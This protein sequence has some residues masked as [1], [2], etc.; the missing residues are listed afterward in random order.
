MRVS[1]PR[2]ARTPASAPVSS[3]AS[4]RL[5]APEV[6]GRLS[7]ETIRRLSATAGNRA[8][9]RVLARK[10]ARYNP[11]DKPIDTAKELRDDY[12]LNTAEQSIR[13][14][15]SKTD[16]KLRGTQLQYLRAIEAMQRSTKEKQ[17]PTALLSKDES[18][19]LIERKWIEGNIASAGSVR[20]GFER[21]A[22]SSS[23]HYGQQAALLRQDIKT[24]QEEFV[25][26]LK[27]NAHDMLDDSQRRIE[28][29]LKGY[30]LVTASADDAVRQVF[31]W[32]GDLD[33]EVEEWLERAKVGQKAI[34]ESKAAT[35][36]REGLSKTI[37]QLRKLQGKILDLQAAFLKK[38][39]KVPLDEHDR[40][41]EDKRAKGQSP[42]S[43]WVFGTDIEPDARKAEEE[44]QVA[45]RELKA[46]WI[47]AERTH[48]IL[49]AHR[50]GQQRHLEFIDLGGYSGSYMPGGLLTSW[51]QPGKIQEARQNLKKQPAKNAHE[52]AVIKQALRKL[53]NIHRARLA[54]RQGK[55]S[56]YKLGPVVE[57]TREQ[58]LIHPRSVWGVAVNELINPHKGPLEE[59]L[60]FVQDLF[61]IAMMLLAAIPNPLQPVAVMY[62]VARGT[63]VTMEEYVKYDLQKSFSD[64]DLDKARSISDEEPSLTGFVVSL[65]ATGMGAAQARTVFK[66]AAAARKAMLAGDDAARKTLNE[67][68]ERH[69][70]GKLGD[71]VARE[72]GITTTPARPTNVNVKPTGKDAVSLKDPP[73]PKPPAKPDKP[74]G[75]DPTQGP[76][77]PGGKRANPLPAPVD[78]PPKMPP[79]IPKPKLDDDLLL[80]PK[81]LTPI[82]YSD[83]AKVKQ[84][85]ADEFKQ[86]SHGVRRSPEEKVLLDD[87][88]NSID[89]SAESQWLKSVYN[90]YYQTLR[91]P[92]A[93]AEFTAHVWQHAAAKNMTPRQ[94]L[95]DL[96]LGGGK[97]TAVTDQLTK[98]HMSKEGGIIDLAFNGNEHGTH[99]HLFQEGLLNFKHG[100]G[101]GKRFRR[102]IGNAK[103]R[104]VPARNGRMKEF[105]ETFWDAMFDVG[106]GNHI[107]RPE[108][109]QPVLERHLGLPRRIT[110]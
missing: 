19:K 44:I 67:L 18:D 61:N 13:V 94:A 71:D 93:Y 38:Y 36:Q 30:G 35:G 96:V 14:E 5:E 15:L 85:A 27:R 31:M 37:Q 80:S 26:A 1:G 48:P 62:D 87:I 105:H 6:G 57:F 82:E 75:Y 16:N 9:G 56:Y 60:E 97:P 69:G 11:M 78:K 86:L 106:D 51:F 64:T 55:L 103:G 81:Q 34:Y 33:K 29:V 50:D 49:S 73:K 63:L 40:R 108:I 52:R 84:G 100:K 41:V 46:A 59:G 39:G 91:D 66:E 110:P 43:K 53:V 45:G 28:N 4:G 23:P 79:P 101:A 65:I 95:E 76:P 58:L 17:R 107:N 109:L 42:V 22:K 10:S 72:A 102:A 20:L 70:V 2:L 89:N 8:V 7:A 54:L 99:T 74:Q 90:D 12:W 92:D 77:K 104:S 32:E 21:T 98:Y 68:G 83:A 24:V 47:K 88:I 3:G 25:S